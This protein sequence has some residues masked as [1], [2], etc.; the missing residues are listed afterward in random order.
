M[1]CWLSCLCGMLNLG[2]R[3][4]LGCWFGGVGLG[5]FLFGVGLLFCDGW[6]LVVICLYL[7][8]YVDALCFGFIGW[9]GC[10]VVYG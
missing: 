5:L 4:L 3:L 10:F 9:F 8:V 2:F 6:V 7:Y 1:G